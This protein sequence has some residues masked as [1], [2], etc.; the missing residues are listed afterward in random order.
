MDDAMLLGGVDLTLLF[1]RFAFSRALS[2]SKRQ[3]ARFGAMSLG[4][5]VVAIIVGMK[6]GRQ[7]RIHHSRTH[8]E[9][10]LQRQE[11]LLRLSS[12]S[13]FLRTLNRPALRALKIER[14]KLPQYSK[15]ALLAAERKDCASN[16]THYGTQ[17][18]RFP[19]VRF[20]T[21]QHGRRLALLTC[22]LH[23]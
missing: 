18:A 14:E 10:I 15:G 22:G 17:L 21:P 5:S 1:N 20:A 7:E 8:L 3:F 6:S 13:E 23:K 11:P 12:D 9:L 19:W 2:L 4:A 16:T